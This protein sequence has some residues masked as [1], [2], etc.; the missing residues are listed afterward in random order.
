M[1]VDISG[2]KSTPLGELA[3]TVTD[4][5]ANGS[6][7]SL[8]ENVS[9]FNTEEYSTLIRLKDYSSGFKGP[10]VYI[11]KHAHEFLKKTQLIPNDIILSNVGSIGAVFRAPDL[12]R[13]MN[14][15]PN[16]ILIRTEQSDDFLFYWF[17]SPIGQEKLKEIAIKTAQPKF[18]KTDLKKITIPL[19]PRNE[20]R[21]IAHVL[22]TVQRAKEATEKV[23][24]HAK[25]LKQSI[26]RYLFTYG[27][28][29][30]HDADKIDLKI[31]ET[32]ETRNDWDCP[33]L[34]EVLTLVYRYPTYYNIQYVEQGIPEIRG[35]LLE[36]DG[37]IKSD[38]DMFRF[39][40]EE[41]SAK[42]PKTRLE[43][44]DIVMSV[45]GTMGKIGIIPP[46]LAGANI[47]ANLIRLS[48]DRKKIL[49]DFLKL[50]LL[51]ENFKRRLNE[52]SPQTTIKT[53]QVRVLCSIPIPLPSLTEQGEISSLALAM[54]AKLRSEE[55]HLNSLRYLFSSLLTNLMSGHIRVNDIDIPE[56]KESS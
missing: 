40:S 53:I 22:R 11:N 42:Y 51:S 26:S 39:I 27:S 31:T 50:T 2:W 29:P 56:L 7:A 16:A 1:S 36:D 37:T 8:R 35:E 6:F 15:G 18:N 3:I 23:I 44:G 28:V 43:E 45:R 33:A 21:A 38:M 25:Q 52:L 17:Q 10:F 48:P 54:D 9:Y 47:T 46:H 14:L 19:P 34:G 49:P 12:G 13:P 4:F 24:A 20:Q 30:Y 32:W 5:V 41:T 55:N